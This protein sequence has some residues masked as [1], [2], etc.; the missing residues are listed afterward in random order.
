MRRRATFWLAWSL[1]GLSVAMFIAGFVLA[2]LT[3]YVADPVKRPSAGGIGE[4]LI[5]SPFLAFPIVGALV[6]SKRPRNPI[7]WICL[8]AGL[9]WMLIVV[10]DQSTSY[11]LATTGSPPGPVMFDALTLFAWVLPVGLL[12]TFMVMLFPDGRL[13]SRRWRPLAWFSGTAILLA[14]VALDLDPGP[15]P[16]RGGIRNPLGIEGHPWIQSVET[17][18][19][20]LLP[21]SIIASAVSLVSRYRHSS[22]EVRQQIKWL[23]F[24]A[25][26]VGVTYL[27]ILVSGILFV[28]DSLFAEGK[29]P[30]WFSLILN[31]LLIS[32][33]SI[34]TAIGF[35]VLKYRLY[36]IDILINRTL[37]YAALTLSLVLVYFGGVV[38]LQYVFRVLTGSE[39]Q[40]AVVASTLL[41]AALFN[42]LRHRIQDFIDRRFYRRKYDAALILATFDTRLREEVDLEALTGELVGVVE[43]TMQPSHVSLWLRGSCRGHR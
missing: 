33:A 1:G 15:L 40:L 25:S 20:L 41:I 37:V 18:C 3:L 21:L 9:L 17:A 38:A 26:F 29:S 43:Q 32:Y 13:P 42:P 31:G 6:A 23:A 12:G 16:H 28:P 34:P 8:T 2:L 7:G 4:I 5:F 30:I 14:S 19:I 11:G 35:A 39:S 10:G 24:A 36:D 22:R 27:S